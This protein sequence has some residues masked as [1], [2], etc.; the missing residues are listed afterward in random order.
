MSLF[1][2]LIGMLLVSVSATQALP[3]EDVVGQSLGGVGEE[4]VTADS[5]T[6]SNTDPTAD[7]NPDITADSTNDSIQI[8]TG[9][10]VDSAVKPVIAEGLEPWLWLEILDRRERGPG[11]VEEAATAF[12]IRSGGADLAVI[13]PSD[14]PVVRMQSPTEVVV[15]LD[16]VLGRPATIRRAAEILSA[17]VSDLVAWGPVSLLSAGAASDA[18]LS[19]NEGIPGSFLDGDT[20]AE[21]FRIEVESGFGPTLDPVLAR[22]TLRDLPEHQVLKVRQQTLSLLRADLPRSAS[23]RLVREAIAEEHE[24]VSRHLGRLLLWAAER[25]VTDPKVLLWVL[26]GFDLDPRLFYAQLGHEIPKEIGLTLEDLVQDTLRDLTGLGWTVLP[27]SPPSV[28]AAHVDSEQ[29]AEINNQQAGSSQPLG[30]PVLRPGR[31]GRKEDR[32]GEDSSGVGS[33]DVLQDLAEVDFIDSSAALELIAAATGAQPIEAASGLRL[34]LAGLGRRWRVDLSPLASSSG[35]SADEALPLRIEGEGSWRASGGSWASGVVPH[36]VT[37]L[38]AERARVE[39]L[40]GGGTRQLPE[41]SVRVSRVVPDSTPVV[42]S[43]EREETALELEA[44]ISRSDESLDL[45]LAIAS[46]NDDRIDPVF[47]VQNLT[48]PGGSEIFFRESMRAPAVGEGR[49]FEESHE[50]VVVL[51][52][53]ATGSWLGRRAT[54]VTGLITDGLENKDLAAN[55]KILRIHLEQEGVARGK[56][57]LLVESR[58]PSIAK[59]VVEVDGV[60]K[61]TLRRKPYEMRLDLGKKARRHQLRVTA[62]DANDL[63]IGSETLILNGGDEDFEVEIVSPRYRRQVGQVMVEAEVS[64]PDGRRIERLFLFWNNENLATLYAPPFRESV[65]IPPEQPLGYIRALAMLDDGR[66]AED[67][68]V[69]NGPETTD[70]LDVELV[71]LYV[72]VN[73]KS[74]HPVQGLTQVDFLVREN[75]KPQQIANFSGA[76]DLPISLGLAIDSS[77]SMFIKLPRMKLAAS[78]FLR[79][80]VGTR[81]RAFVV[82]F[83]SRPRLAHGLTS[84]MEPLLGSIDSLEANGRTALWESIVFSL[85]QLQGVGGRKALVV[86]TDGA[87]EDDRFPFHSAMGI[88]KKM[89]VPIYL[90]LMTERSEPGGALSLFIRSFSERVDRL[91]DGTGGRIF[92]VPEYEDLAAVYNEIEDELRAQYLLTY[93]PGADSSGGSE[94]DKGNPVWRNVEV[95]CRQPELKA[96][97]LSGYWD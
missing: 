43:G 50:V 89:G 23:G 8:S 13:P 21:H 28:R 95:L 87:D 2:C 36:Q 82:D 85:V 19:S 6:D 35:Q 44:R 90:I 88:A 29:L 4:H 7:S 79:S 40:S 46:W 17:S 66:L 53:L 38:R 77:A 54:I 73:D 67:V 58:D 65:R 9:S 47:E 61:K 26:D 62:L 55:N 41:F 70:R 74:G 33:S 32:D 76:S 39:G 30:G 83:D 81:D 94:V 18:F 48:H 80:V 68:I 22:L 57:P 96:R 75:E 34:T 93:Y 97:T 52:D 25:P 72:V 59:I 12:R 64:V 63:E 16:S 86:F 45:R 60:E 27:L 42:S 24:I 78:R 15:L 5:N 71:E 51:E 69:M 91:V 20:G 84:E 56:V 14:S 3:P 1:L 49:T 10:R 31:W 11:S 37:R 92:Y